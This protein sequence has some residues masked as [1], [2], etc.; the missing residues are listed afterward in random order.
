MRNSF[1]QDA[2]TPI[3]DAL[4][5]PN[6]QLL[7]K[8]GEVSINDQFSF[9]V[10]SVF[11]EQNWTKP[12]NPDKINIGL[13][14]GAIRNSRTDIGF[15][16]EHGE[17]DISIFEDC[18]YAF[19][20]DIHK[21]QVL[22]H[23]GHIAYAGSTIQQNF[24]ETLDKGIFIW[25]IKSKNEFTR[26]KFDFVN[27]KPFITII[28]TNAGKIPSNFT[29]Q[30]GAR[31]RLVSNT[32][33]PL[34]KLRKA[35]EIA[36]HKYKP[37]SVTFLNKASNDDLTADGKINSEIFDNLRDEKVQQDLIK[38]YLKDYKVSDE[39]LDEIYALNSKYNKVVEESEDISRN[40]HWKIKRFEWDNL[41]NYGEGN[42][43]D[44]Q[45]LSGTV[46]VFGKNYSGKSS[47]VDSL[48][49]TIYNDTSKNI[50]KTFNIINQNKDYGCGKVE[51]E[52]NNKL[53][54]ITRK[55]EKY[56]KKLKGKV[57][58][59]A[60]TQVDFDYVDLVSGEVG[61]VNQ[62]E[63]NGTDK[64]I[65]NIF[66]DM[67]DFLTTSMSSQM[68]ALSFINEGSTR[69]KEIL[70][71]FLDLEF[72]ENKFKLAKDDA[73]DLKG[74]LKRVQDVDYDTSIALVKTNIFNEE[75]NLLK[76]KN[77]CTDLKQNLTLLQENISSLEAQVSQTPSEFASMI[78]VEEKL[79]AAKA[80]REKIVK[81]IADVHA[82]ITE[83]EA[84]LTKCD[85]LLATINIT[86]LTQKEQ[87]SVKLQKEID[88]LLSN[89]TKNETNL[90]INKKQIEILNG[91]PCGS[92]YLTTC[93][94]I[95]EANEA[96]DTVA[97]I[98][99]VI[100][101][102][103]TKIKSKEDQNNNIDLSQVRKTIDNFNKLTQKRSNENSNISISKVKLDLLNS[104]LDK[105]E[106]EIVDLTKNIE[107]AEKNKEAIKN[108]EK[109]TNLLKEKKAELKTL[110]TNLDLEE[111]KMYSLV[112]T[113][114]ATEQK[115][116]NLE[117]QKL[118]REQMNK[119]YSAYDL[120]MTCMHSSGIA[121]DVIKKALPIINTEI[122]KV[123][124]NIVDFE[125]FFE[126]NENKLD[127]LIKHPKYDPRPLENGSGAEKTLA[128]IAIRI[129][130]LN[131]S[132]MPKSNLFILDEPGTALD[133]ENMEGF[134]RI[135]DLVKSY[136][137]VTLLITHIESL[138]DIVDTTIEISKTDDGYAF[139]SQ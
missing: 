84:F 52:A 90:S 110:L 54:T 18:D 23:A 123:L 105:V 58:D 69:R 56:T 103:E 16:M 48:L 33:I 15:I 62:T 126:N 130:L 10:L 17:H 122:T 44:F 138:K 137:D 135:L 94:F 89:K 24:G 91:I 113:L 27:P 118:S 98:E 42:A 5:H 70:A 37:E 86:D 74:A 1:R 66:G 129:A 9:N 127:I 63:R 43:I 115:K 14:H 29:C 13:Y 120:F 73:A 128:A 92:S 81:D 108:F 30:E 99:K 41:F 95:R 109:V 8:A 87:D 22:D 80:Q 38:E 6:L 134:I 35:V 116:V 100:K 85:A 101:E 132:N 77:L 139:V 106:K 12:S 83:K 11:D 26:T 119:E 121:F 47:I 57:T 4:S 51:I 79:E 20:G 104:N 88:D 31:L 133:P 96:N 125:V 136:F 93:K 76:Q 64:S 61:S 78:H 7:K 102:L 114:G 72:F 82:L 25:D 39:T 68:G 19:L 3:V 107:E 97:L 60:K 49:Y 2:I 112:A 46:G 71:K 59:E 53:Y 21:T 67:N 28:L 36:K 75:A 117:E 124:S 111:N 50:R 34:E 65:T 131:I 32:N 45:N 40:V 55:S